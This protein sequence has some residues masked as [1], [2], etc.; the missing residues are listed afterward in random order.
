MD[1]VGDI[2]RDYLLGSYRNK[3]GIGM[4]PSN[5]IKL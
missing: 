3:Y 5:E 4:P 2:V 1:D